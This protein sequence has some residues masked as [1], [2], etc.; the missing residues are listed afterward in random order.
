MEKDILEDSVFDGARLEIDAAI[1]TSGAE[2]IGIAMSFALAGEF[3]SRG[4]L[5]IVTFEFLGSWDA[6]KYRG[7]YVFPDPT[8]DDAEFRFAK[9]NG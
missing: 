5:E 9:A 3:M 2:N 1:D 7:R 8:L 4:L 6:R